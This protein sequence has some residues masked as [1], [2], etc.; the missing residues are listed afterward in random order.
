MKKYFFYMVVVSYACCISHIDI[1]AEDLMRSPENLNNPPENNI[2]PPKTIEKKSPEE[3]FL[4]PE[5]NWSVG[6]PLNFVRPLSATLEI[7]GTSI[8]YKIWIDGKIW[9][10]V[11]K[12]N[13]FAERSFAMNYDR[14]YAIIVPQKIEFPLISLEQIVIKNARENGFD[15]VKVLSS[16]KRIVNGKAVLFLHWKAFVQGSEVEFLSYIYSGPEGSIFLHT[17]TLSSLYPE[18]KKAMEDFLNGFSI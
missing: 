11:S 9:T 13:E 8:P 17:Y 5:K 7:K 14:V 15:Q 6:Q 16:E 1:H 2:N 18:N 10:E 3:I 4:K 12:L